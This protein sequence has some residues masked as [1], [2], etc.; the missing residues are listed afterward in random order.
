MTGDNV[1][2]SYRVRL[3]AGIAIRRFSGDE[4]RPSRAGL[5]RPCSDK[6]VRAGPIEPRIT[7]LFSLP[8]HQV[9][10]ILVQR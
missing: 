3:T 5:G 4:C 9:R 6:A 1:T 8:S 10:W 2:R 7:S